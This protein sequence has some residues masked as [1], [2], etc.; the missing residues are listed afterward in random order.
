MPVLV[1]L[2]WT[3]GFTGAWGW[4]LLKWALR[5]A[6]WILVRTLW[7]TLALA[8][9]LVSRRL[10]GW[11]WTRVAVSGRRGRG[12]WGDSPEKRT[13][14]NGQREPPPVAANLR[15]VPAQRIALASY[16]AQRYWTRAFDGPEILE[17]LVGPA[18]TGKTE[19]K[20]GQI[21]AGFD[22]EPFCGLPTSRC[23]RILLLS[24]M[25]GAT[26]Q[27][28][29]L[30]WEFVTPPTGTLDGIRLRYLPP[31]GYAGGLIDVVYAADVYTPR[32][33]DGVLQET[34][35]AAV[36]LAVLT[37]VRKGRYDRVIIDSLGEWMGSDNNAAMLNT[38]G[39]SA[40]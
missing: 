32:M 38:L 33:I 40:N 6:W 36:I 27:P 35:W 13:P 1:A 10:A 19:V 25:G 9:L 22:G 7:A 4:R 16:D 30:R 5:A 12:V 15:P 37:L 8:A 18:G 31:Q 2:G 34:D 26:L 28:A 11:C 17:M 21:R 14:D 20:L 3:V 23:K 24:E 39:A 29:L